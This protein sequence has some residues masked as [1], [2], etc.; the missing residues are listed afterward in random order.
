M[1]HDHV[2]SHSNILDVEKFYFHKYPCRKRHLF[3]YGGSSTVFT[4]TCNAYQNNEL[5]NNVLSFGYICKKMHR[6]KLEI[7][8]SLYT[9]CAFTIENDGKK[10]IAQY[11]IKSNA[12]N[13]KLQKMKKE[14]K[15]KL[16]FKCVCVCFAFLFVF[17]F[18][19]GIEPGSLQQ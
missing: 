1:N 5:C 16:T 4:C 17:F 12:G 3:T 10:Y 15:E 9:T 13:I 8:E 2:C 19:L 14:R 11:M 18:I 6:T 7:S